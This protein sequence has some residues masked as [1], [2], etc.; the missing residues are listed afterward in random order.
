MYLTLLYLISQKMAGE[1]KPHR[2]ITVRPL[3][4]LLY[5]YQFT[6]LSW[7]RSLWYVPLT[8][9]QNATLAYG[10]ICVFIFKSWFHFCVLK[11]DFVFLHGT[12]RLAREG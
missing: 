6:F 11:N 1:K 3:H 5:R 4:L 10:T 12:F 7:R 2:Y 9:L 8:P